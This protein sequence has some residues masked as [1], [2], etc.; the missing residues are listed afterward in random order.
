[1]TSSN[2]KGKHEL[3]WALRTLKIGDPLRLS[4][5]GPGLLPPK[6]VAQDGR[7]QSEVA[8][9]DVPGKTQRSLTGGNRLDGE[10][11]TQTEAPKKEVAQKELSQIEVAKIE[12]PHLE[13]SQSEGAA[14]RVPQIEIS[15]NKEA[16]ELPVMLTKPAGF[17]KL[18]HSVFSEPCLRELSG[19]CFR[20]FLW[21][22]AKAWR[23][24]NSQGIVRASIHHMEIQTAMGHATISRALKA[25]KE[26][27]L[28][29][30]VATD[31]KKGNVWK[32]S[33]IA[34]GPEVP[35]GG[36]LKNKEPQIEQ[37]SPN[38]A[39]SHRAQSS[40]GLRGKLPQNEHHFK[41]NK[42]L[43]NKIKKASGC[44]IEPPNYRQSSVAHE[45]KERAIAKFEEEISSQEREGW[46]TKFIERE[47]PHGFLPPRKVI[48]SMAAYDWFISKNK[49]SE[50]RWAV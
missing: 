48:F 39:S 22:S 18:A 41:G 19:D 35:E 44:A 28:V 1:M 4:K 32:I 26:A 33:P 14:S 7:P 11:V 40:L 5:S 50:S 46:V 3:R 20:L 21:L 24:P 42:N 2:R 25:L 38:L 31:F 47:F 29:E 13:L 6:E 49:T 34:T 8:H 43:I 30:L 36:G 15:Q 16:S 27:R 23:Y 17:F 45:L 9:S 12:T 10:R 37:A